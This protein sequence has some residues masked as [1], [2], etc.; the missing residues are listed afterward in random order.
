MDSFV[1]TYEYDNGEIQRVHTVILEKGLGF[2]FF[3]PRHNPLAFERICTLYRT[4]TVPRLPIIFGRMMHFCLPE[5][6]E[7]P[8]KVLE[9]CRAFENRYGVLADDLNK[10]TVAFREA[11]RIRRDGS[12]FERKSAGAG[13]AVLEFYEYLK[14]RGFAKVVCGKLPYNKFLPVSNDFGLLS[15]SEKDAEIRANST[16]FVMDSFDVASAYDCIGTPIGLTVEEGTVLTPPLFGREAFAVRKNGNVAIEKITLDDLC[17]SVGGFKFKNGSE[18]VS[19]F[20]RPGRAKTPAASRESCAELVIV[21]RKVRAVKRGGNTVIP[22]SGFVIRLDMRQK[23]F[24]DLL[25]DE[26]FF[27]FVDAPVAYEGLEDVRFAVAAG[28]PAVIEGEKVLNFRAKF[29]NIKKLWTVKYPPTLF[30]VDFER[31][32]A[33]RMVIGALK[34]GRLSLV[35]AEGKSKFNYEPGV[36]SCGASLKEMADICE[37]IGLYNAVHL[38]GGGSAQLLLNGSRKLKISDRNKADKS[39]AERAVPLGICLTSQSIEG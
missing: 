32:R 13:G 2:R 22:A 29:Y 7:V 26:K 16:F 4:F 38:D 1:K 31:A 21:G 18:G 33:P 19:F 8:E 5:G 24:V 3:K 6:I 37:D 10:V 34:D 15:E 23:R 39:E 17:V 36:E 12:V 11:L 25:D 14:S 27:G 35:W 20:E 28:N 30:P 9:F